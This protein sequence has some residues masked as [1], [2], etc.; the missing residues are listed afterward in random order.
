M[1]PLLTP[2]WVVTFLIA[3]TVT[4]VSYQAI[5]HNLDHLEKDGSAGI[6]SQ[7]VSSKVFTM[8]VRWCGMDHI[9]MSYGM[10]AIA[11]FMANGNHLAAAILARVI[12]VSSVMVAFISAL[13]AVSIH[14]E[15]RKANANT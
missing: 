5:P 14:I 12:V 10:L 3:A 9:I 13:S 4:F 7:L 15:T 11:M 8:F 2:F 6:V 1:I